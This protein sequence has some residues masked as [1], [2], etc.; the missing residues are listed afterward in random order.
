MY[1]GNICR[2]SVDVVK[3][4]RCKAKL[5]LIGRP[6]ITQICES[7]FSQLGFT[8]QLN[9]PSGIGLK[10]SDGDIGWLL[11]GFTAVDVFAEINLTD[12][13]FGENYLTASVY[14]VETMQLFE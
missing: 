7:N 1:F 13:L 10:N 4:G 5:L 14:F 12:C 6:K 2:R 11:G 3:G 8:A 9:S